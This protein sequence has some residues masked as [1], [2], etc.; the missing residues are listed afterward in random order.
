M[1][2]VGVHV[3]VLVGAFVAVPVGALAPARLLVSFAHTSAW[4]VVTLM[5]GWVVALV[6]VQ[7]V[8]LVVVVV[9]ILLYVVVDAV[10]V[11]LAYCVA[12]MDTRPAEVQARVDW[13]PDAL[14]LV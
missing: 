5:I 13:T 7:F 9:T 3:V 14:V 2:F 6:E 11:D 12:L 4:L 1:A 8:V 10:A